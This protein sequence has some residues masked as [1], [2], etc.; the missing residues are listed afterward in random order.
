MRAASTK[1]H[2]PA[3]AG[4]P[5]LGFLGVGWI[6]KKR[7][8]ALAASSSVDIVCVA[9]T[10][11]ASALEAL[12]AIRSQ[13]PRARAVGSL[14]AMLDEGLDGIVIA[15]PSALHAQQ[16]IAALSHGLAVFCQKPL[17]CSAAE[18]DRVIAAARAHDRLL[19][20]DL[21]YRTVAG[22]PRMAALAH[23]GALG[24]IYA[25]DLVFHNAYGPD[26]P[27][28]Y[29]INQSGGGCG[30]DLGTHLLDLLLWVLDSP[31]VTSVSSRVYARGRPLALPV[32]QIEDYCMAEV[33]FATGA[34]ARIACSWG[35]NAGR[36]AVIEAT[37]HGTLG[38]AVLRNVQGSFQDF[39]V[40]HCEGTHRRVLAAPPDDWGGR[41]IA[42]WARQV[43]V[44]PGFDP[45][46]EQ[47]TAV[48]ALVD[49]VYGRAVPRAGPAT[50]Q[51][52]HTLAGA[53][54]H[55]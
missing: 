5:R 21:C 34:S 28:F 11:Q 9:D 52:D 32:T 50:P 29:D 45:S 43:G 18:T 47:L 31:S 30:I 7:L 6:G 10:S 2:A 20:V 4:S 39:T 22:V 26:K 40:E 1:A 33:S 8:I 16:A 37:F 23:E 54:G 38:A 44:D 14:E 55:A 36:D 25:A 49:A 19:A 42:R 27:W 48:A 35:A 46:C 12:M 15:T 13:A 24:Q 3:R 17:A 51:G 53:T 41:A